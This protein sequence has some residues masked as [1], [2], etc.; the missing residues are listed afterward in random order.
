MCMWKTKKASDA[1]SMVSIV[2]VEYF[3]WLNASDANFLNKIE[4][5]AT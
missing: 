4:K 5:N 2:R 1:S 3:F